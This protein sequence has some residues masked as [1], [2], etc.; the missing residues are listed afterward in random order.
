MC[1][2]CEGVLEL[3]HGGAAASNAPVLAG[4]FSRG[5]HLHL[6]CGAA[7]ERRKDGRKEGRKEEKRGGRRRHAFL[8][9]D[10]W[11]CSR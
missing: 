7:P 8:S 1:A 5:R 2:C 10:V 6:Y 11:S 4:E 3:L 9:R